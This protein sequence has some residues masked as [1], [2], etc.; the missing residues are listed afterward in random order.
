LATTAD[1][2]NAAVADARDQGGA[3]AAQTS[4]I[5]GDAIREEI[6]NKGAPVPYIKRILENKLNFSETEVK[7]ALEAA[8]AEEVADAS[9]SATSPTQAPEVKITGSHERVG[10]GVTFYEIQWK[11]GHGSSHNVS[12]RYNEFNTLRKDLISKFQLTEVKYLRFP[13]K[14]YTR[15]RPEEL[16]NFLLELLEL[17][18]PR[19]GKGASGLVYDFLHVTSKSDK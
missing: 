12:R 16:E 2:I 17:V 6:L 10:D 3:S 7:A 18:V 9:N 11:D 19:K 5:V 14:K 8:N 13:G 15:T 4:K 1:R